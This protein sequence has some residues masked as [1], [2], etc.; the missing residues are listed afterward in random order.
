MI[1]MR[2]LC[3]LTLATLGVALSAPA[4]HA[5][6]L[7]GQE[8]STL[9]HSPWLALRIEQGGAQVPL[10]AIDTLRSEVTLNRQPFTIVMPV[11]GEDDTYWITAWNDD[12]IFADAEPDRRSRRWEEIGP[13]PYFAGGTGLADTAAGSGTLF[14]DNRGHHHLSGLR[15]G[16]DYYRHVFNVSSVFGDWADGE[17]GR[18]PLAEVPSP[19]Y[20]VAWFDEDGDGVMRHGEYEFL[21]LHFR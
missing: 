10:A 14:L 3:L 8:E 5:L 13:P 19:L 21:V 16:P 4:P 12:S 2:R 6:A 15:L 11:R 18:K 20:L 1:A 9:P 17:R 7:D